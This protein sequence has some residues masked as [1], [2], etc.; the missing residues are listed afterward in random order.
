MAAESRSEAPLPVHVRVLLPAS[1]PKG[2]IQPIQTRLR[3]A[4]MRMVRRVEV[5]LLFASGALAGCSTGSGSQQYVITPSYAE[6]LPPSGC[7]LGCTAAEICAYPLDAGCDAAGVCVPL[8]ASAPPCKA[9]N[10]C[11]C[12]G[13]VFLGRCDVPAGYSQAPS[14][15]GYLACES[16][17][18]ADGGSE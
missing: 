2:D 7:P 5:L 6:G 17:A 8:N 1:H 16:N 13:I 15:G 4:S 9:Y 10:L 18:A 14:V 12:N 11:G 3:V